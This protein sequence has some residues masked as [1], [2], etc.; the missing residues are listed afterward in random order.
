MEAIGQLGT[1]RWLAFGFAKGW[2]WARE[3]SGV[4]LASEGIQACARDR[5]SVIAGHGMDRVQDDLTRQL[6][7]SV[8]FWAATKKTGV[9]CFPLKPLSSK[10]R[11]VGKQTSNNNLSLQVSIYHI[12]RLF[13]RLCMS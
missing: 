3:R 4:A 1:L 5:S 13:C 10:Y 8:C 6:I 12:F 11:S 9:A 7:V 2:A